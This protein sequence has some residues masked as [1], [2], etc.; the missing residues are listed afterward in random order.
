MSNS[1]IAQSGQPTPCADPT[2]QRC[3]AHG[4]RGAL[5][6]LRDVRSQWAVRH[7][8]MIAKAFPL[9]KKFGLCAREVFAV[10]K[11]FAIFGDGARPTARLVRLRAPRPGP[12]SAASGWKSDRPEDLTRRRL[13]ART[14][15]GSRLC[16]CAEGTSS[17]RT[18]ERPGGR[19]Q[20]RR[21][22]WRPGNP[23]RTE[24]PATGRQ[25]LTAPGS[26]AGE[27]RISGEAAPA[28]TCPSSDHVEPVRN[29]RHEV[30]YEVVHVT[31]STWSPLTTHPRLHNKTSQRVMCAPE[32]SNGACVPL[33]PYASA[34]ATPYNSLTRSCLS[35]GGQVRNVPLV[36]VRH[37]LPGSSYNA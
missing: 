13:F 19:G 37:K 25:R 6:R 11:V 2:E 20:A 14:N 17:P 33:G 9:G 21:A 28:I 22:R 7:G 35:S 24:D 18:R 30:N 31:P 1:T 36:A 3:S 32:M 34:C 10:R 26:R 12:R 27:T 5:A 15:D 8:A 29:D 16:S 23:R 4:A